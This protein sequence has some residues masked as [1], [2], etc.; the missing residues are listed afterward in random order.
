MGGPNSLWQHPP[1]QEEEEEGRERGGG[2]K[3]K[4]VGRRGDSSSLYPRWV[5]EERVGG[6]VGCLG[7][8]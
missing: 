2:E 5:G 7:H 4:G 8:M 6:W 1:I 3:E